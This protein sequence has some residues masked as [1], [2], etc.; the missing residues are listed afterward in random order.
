MKPN[1]LTHRYAK[2]FLEL[3]MQKDVV[4]KCHDDL[5]LVKNTFDNNEELRTL[6]HQPFLSKER[7]KNI[8]TKLFKERTESI[9]VDFLCLLIE[10]D[11]D[12]LLSNIYDVFHELYLDYKKIA[13]VTVTSAVDLDDNTINRIVN[14]IKHKIV[15]KVT[16]EVEKNIDKTIIGGFIVRYNDYEYDASVRNTLKRLQSEFEKN[17][18]VKEY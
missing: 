6:I 5:R 14:I 8:L 10:K 18:F 1:I 3:A 4:D 11:R 15:G 12:E 13:V 17:L 7:K 2:A 16:I 9:T